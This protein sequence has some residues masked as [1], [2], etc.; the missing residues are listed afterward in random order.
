MRTVY[1]DIVILKGLGMESIM[2]LE[3]LSIE[4]KGGKKIVPFP[5]RR[6]QLGIAGEFL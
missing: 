2:L 5:R 1:R 6:N 4:G 3:T